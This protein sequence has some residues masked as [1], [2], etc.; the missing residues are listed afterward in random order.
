MEI[1]VIVEVVVVV[2]E[3]VVVE[4][5]V[6]TTILTMV[7]LLY[8][9]LNWTALP[10]T[11]HTD[12]VVTVVDVV[13]VKLV[14]VTLVV[15]SGIVV[16]VV[17][18]NK[19]AND[20]AVLNMSVKPVSVGGPIQSVLPKRP[21]RVSSSWPQAAILPLLL[22]ATNPRSLPTIFLQPLSLGGANG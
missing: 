4:V 10:L 13:V 1:A 18:P 5:V 3:V 22:S 6:V 7:P 19:A 17:T 11:D 21:M 9:Y 14:D 20:A 12:T 2:T 8:S 16:V 15:K